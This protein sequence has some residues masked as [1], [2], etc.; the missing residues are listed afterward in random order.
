MNQNDK[1]LVHH[2]F[3]FFD[4]KDRIFIR[5][6]NIVQ[7]TPGQ[8]NTGVKILAWHEY[9][10]KKPLGKLTKLCIQTKQLLP[11]VYIF[12]SLAK[13]LVVLQQCHCPLGE[14]R[15]GG[16]V[17]YQKCTYFVHSIQPMKL[18]PT[19]PFHSSSTRTLVLAP[20]CRNPLQMSFVSATSL[21][22][23]P[24]HFQPQGIPK[25]REPPSHRVVD[26]LH[27]PGPVGFSFDIDLC[28]LGVCQNTPARQMF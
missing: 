20:D 9:A 17:F 18:Q 6:G 15:W 23:T 3:S 16:F 2:F 11:L 5:S 19:L 24:I 25:E 21:P 14:C 7:V 13:P 22:P 10:S 1:F 4:S 28:R 12:Y 27:M 8:R 26:R